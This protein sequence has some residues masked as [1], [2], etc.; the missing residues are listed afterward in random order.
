M[1]TEVGNCSKGAKKLPRRLKAPE[2]SRTSALDKEENHERYS[3]EGSAAI[4]T[5]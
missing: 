2:I 1:S 3:A 4:R 5:S